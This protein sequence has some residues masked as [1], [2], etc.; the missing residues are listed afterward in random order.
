MDRYDYLDL[1]DTWE[2]IFDAFLLKDSL[3]NELE[4]YHKWIPIFDAK[5][6]S[7]LT[8]VMHPDGEGGGDSQTVGYLKAIKNSY[9][10]RR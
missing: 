6:R 2:V 4:I 1:E 9:P 3:E 7:H 10:R 8:S 5:L